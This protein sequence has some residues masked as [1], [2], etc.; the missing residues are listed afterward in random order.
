MNKVVLS[1]S[2]L[3]KLQNADD[4]VEICDEKGQ[5]QGFV[6]PAEMHREMMSAWLKAMFTDE[7]IEAARR[8]PGG[9]PTADAVAY[10]E[11]VA[12][13]HRRS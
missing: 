2:E 6:V 7:E 11:K 9:M 3:A 8:E 5:T 1:Q 4:I 12:E 10:L 13:E